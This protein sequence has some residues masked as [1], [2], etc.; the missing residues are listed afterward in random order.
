MMAGKEDHKERVLV[1][2]ARHKILCVRTTQSSFV[3][4][5]YQLR[6]EILDALMQVTPHFRLVS[7]T[8]LS[9]SSQ[10]KDTISLR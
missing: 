9:L 1:V 2:F 7:P 8:Q 10:L 6:I 5:E 4:S 3:T